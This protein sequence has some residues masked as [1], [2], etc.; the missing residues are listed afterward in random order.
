MNQRRSER[1][2]YSHF[3]LCGTIIIF[4]FVFVASILNAIPAF[5]ALGED[6]SSVQADQAHMQGV[7]RTTRDNAYTLQEIQAPSGTVVRE[8]VSGLGKV[9]AVAWQGSWP[10][11]MRQ[12]LGSYFG[13]YQEA[14]QA[15]INAHAGRRPLVI[16]RPGFVLESGGHMRSFAGRA[17]IP[18]MVPAGISAEA[19]R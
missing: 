2:R 9:F 1:C 14:A 7:L 12:I 6:V 3:G 18:E 5:A 15:Q 8:Y 17:Y 10:P 13:Q 19:I 4:I 11:D 16:Q